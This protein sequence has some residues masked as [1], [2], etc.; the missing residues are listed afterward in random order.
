[1]GKNGNNNMII[2]M[3]KHLDNEITFLDENIS[4]LR[5]NITELNHQVVDMKQRKQK[6]IDKKKK[7]EKEL[8]KTM[9][10]LSPASEDNC[11]KNHGIPACIFKVSKKEWN[12]ITEEITSRNSP[13]IA[14]LDCSNGGH[15][16]I[17]TLNLTSMHKKTKQIFKETYIPEEE[18][19]LIANESFIQMLRDYI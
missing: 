18:Y 7:L 15:G 3:E 5:E 6:L 2:L 9:Y 1:M 13:I 19:K 16:C 4:N 14:Q 11:D 12:E 17:I 10:M 8:S